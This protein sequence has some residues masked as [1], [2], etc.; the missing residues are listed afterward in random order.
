MT[1]A[2][3]ERASLSLKNLDK[4]TSD[5]LF[6]WTDQSGEKSLLLRR[7]GDEATDRLTAIGDRHGAASAAGVLVV[8][9]PARCQPAACRRWAQKVA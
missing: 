5:Y 8:V 3:K 4:L 1:A 7:R 9:P 2:N 6:I